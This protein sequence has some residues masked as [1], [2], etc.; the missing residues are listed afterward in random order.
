MLGQAPG[1]G[2]VAV[3]VLEERVEGRRGS[4]LH[5]LVF[6]INKWR[7]LLTP[8][9]EN[10]RDFDGEPRSTGT[11]TSLVSDSMTGT[12]NFDTGLC[13]VNGEW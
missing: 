12:H 3:D 10:R 9:P 5:L 8:E 7:S 6:D 1:L 13:F 2:H 4:V 11:I